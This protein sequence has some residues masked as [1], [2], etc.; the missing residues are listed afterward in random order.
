[1]HV[2]HTGEILV[3]AIVL[4][5]C[6]HIERARYHAHM[7]LVDCRDAGHMVTVKSMM[8]VAAAVVGSD[9]A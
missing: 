9:D 4:R 6:T 7:L 2:R 3:L 1:M 8:D 5:T